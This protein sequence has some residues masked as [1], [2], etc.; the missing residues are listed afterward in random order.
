[1]EDIISG[2]GRGVL[3]VLDGFDELPKPLQHE[4]V[5]VDLMQKSIL[6]VS[7]ILVTSRPSGMDRLLTISKP[8][9]EKHIE[10]LGFF[11][12]SIEAHA[13]SVFCGVE[14]ESFKKYTSA[15]QNP[16]INSF[17]YVPLYAAFV[18][19]I[20]QS[21]T[22]KG[23]LPRTITQLY[24]QLCLTILNRYLEAN[25]E[26]PSVRTIQHL[27]RRRGGEGRGGG[28]EE[29]GEGR[30]EKG[31]GREGG[32]ERRGR[33]EEK[34]EGERRRGRG[35]GE[36]GGGEEKGRSWSIVWAVS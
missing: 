18:V 28:G 35:R 34:G 1:M 12:E 27:Q 2:H 9:I 22:S 23:S 32:G 8:V 26:Y 3:F 19:I 21:T 5:L 24:T 36:G 16:A 31:E 15:P 4:G 17:M 7:T 10:I 14:L 6:P 20:Y 33:G 11:Q 29:K 25:T 30:G 13:S